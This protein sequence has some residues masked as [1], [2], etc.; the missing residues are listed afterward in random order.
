MEDIF[1]SFTASVTRAYKY[2]SHIKKTESLNLGIKGIHVMTI[3]YLEKYDEGLTV[4]ELAA[5]CCEDKA[6]V[7]RNLDSLIK[8]GYVRYAKTDGSK[9]RRSKAVLT[10]EGI[11]AAGEVNKVIDS[12][13]QE[14]GLGISKRDREI[15]YR[16][17]VHINNNLAEYIEK[18]CKKPIRG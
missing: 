17:F 2:I 10:D 4:S 9:H 7:S 6:A 8:M 3:V 5:M 18:N 12:I 15:F 14:I 1:E 13:V 11:K 16:V